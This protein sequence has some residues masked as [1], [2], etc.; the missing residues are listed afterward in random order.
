M[1]RR[2]RNRATR[3]LFDAVGLF[4]I[5]ILFAGTA[6]SDGS[7]SMDVVAHVIDMADS[8]EDGALAPEEY[9]EAALESYGVTFSE[10]DVNA[11]GFVTERE[12]R[13]LYMIHHDGMGDDIE[14]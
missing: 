4:A 12:Y 3:K 9:A 10:C 11:D 5:I 2:I 14:L 7:E 13:D 8:D 1:L 6:I